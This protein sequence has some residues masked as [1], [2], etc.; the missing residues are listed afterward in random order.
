[1]GHEFAWSCHR[2]GDCCLDVQQIVLT[3]AEVEALTAARPDVAMVVRPHHADQRFLV[4]ETPTGC[5]MLARELDGTPTCTVYDVRPYQ[6]RRFMCL[7]EEGEPFRAGGPMGC[8]NLSDRLETNRHAL[9]FYGSHQRR[10][11]KS[12]ADAHGWTK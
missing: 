12:W 9:A 5:P 1:M 8:R 3:P 11:Q 6:C 10:A 4:W 7:R 2:S